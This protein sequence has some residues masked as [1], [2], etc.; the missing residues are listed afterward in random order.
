MLVHLTGVQLVER[1][2]VLVACAF[3]KTRQ[4]I[5]GGISFDAENFPRELIPA[6]HGVDEVP[7]EIRLILKLLR[8][9]FAG[10]S[11]KC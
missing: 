5:F 6:A 4:R 10:L 1:Y 9:A 11:V 8:T 7:A 3:E 2:P